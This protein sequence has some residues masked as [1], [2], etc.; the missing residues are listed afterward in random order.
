VRSSARA[1]EQVPARFIT[2]IRSGNTGADIEDRKE[3]ETEIIGEPWMVNQG[4]F[5]KRSEVKMVP[6]Q[7]LL[8]LTRR[9]AEFHSTVNGT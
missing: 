9:P 4:S 3:I 1:L 6:P 7:T 2:T 8:G 5:A